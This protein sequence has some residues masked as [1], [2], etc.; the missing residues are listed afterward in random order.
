MNQKWKKAL[1]GDEA[2]AWQATF[3]DVE[4]A[5]LV[6][7]GQ[8]REITN[9]KEIEA[10]PE[11]QFIGVLIRCTTKRDSDGVE[12]RK[13]LRAALRGDLFSGRHDTYSPSLSWGTFLC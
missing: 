8:V 9:T 13:K 3:E 4:V 1:V 2:E 5:D 11:H 12:I 6:R 10:I 7:R